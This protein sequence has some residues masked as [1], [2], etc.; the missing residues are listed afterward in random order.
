MPASWQ[1]GRPFFRKGNNMACLE[2]NQGCWG[3]EGWIQWQ[4]HMLCHHHHPNFSALPTSWLS[5]KMCPLC[6][7]HRSKN[8]HNRWLDSLPGLQPQWFACFLFVQDSGQQQIIGYWVYQPTDLIKYCNKA[9]ILWAIRVPKSHQL[10]WDLS[11]ST[12]CKICIIYKTVENKGDENEM[13]G[14]QISVPDMCVGR[15][16]KLHLV[17]LLAE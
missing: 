17:F 13:R 9:E 2:R 10:K 5:L 1:W 15:A 16:A 6:S 3:W 14:S 12:M 7:W 8:T 4:L 11:S